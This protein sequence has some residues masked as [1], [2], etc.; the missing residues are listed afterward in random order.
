MQENVHNG[1]DRDPTCLSGTAVLAD[2]D[3]ALVREQARTM[4]HTESDATIA[5]NKDGVIIYWDRAAQAMFGYSPEEA[6]GKEFNLLVPQEYHVLNKYRIGLMLQTGEAEFKGGPVDL[7]VT[8]KDGSEI[9]S[10]FDPLMIKTQ[11]ETL[12]I[13]VA[14]DITEKE[15]AG[16]TADELNENLATLG[17]KLQLNIADIVEAA[18]TTLQGAYALYQRSEALVMLRTMSGWNLPGNVM[19]VQRQK[20]T[21]SFDILNSEKE[22]PMLYRDLEHSPF[23][24]ADPSLVKNNI[25]SCM[26]W[27]VRAGGKP[28][29][30]LSVFFNEKKDFRIIE[31]KVFEV[32]ARALEGAVE[33]LMTMDKYKLNRRKLEIANDKIKRLSRSV[34]D[35]REIEKKNL[36]MTLHDEL[37]AAVVAIFSRLSIAEEEI[38]DRDL[39]AAL[40]QLSQLKNVINSSFDGLKKIVHDLRPPEL[41]FIGLESVLKMFFSSVSAQTD[42]NIRFRCVLENAV[43]KDSITISLYRFVQECINNIIKHAEAKNAEVFLRTSGEDV[44]LDVRDDG[45]G[46]EVENVMQNSGSSKMGIWGMQMRTESLGGVFTINAGRR[47]GTQVTIRIPYKGERA[48]EH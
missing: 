16:K 2:D 18:G 19:K 15:Q 22:G 8:C 13:V 4:Y 33:H 47:W 31:L 41:D 9:F 43:L 6:L 36:A 34:M 27:P 23:A 29:G 21:V 25:R 45:R 12:F 10:E 26:G 1:P 37:G 44:C 28:V 3:I 5:I 14:R 7:S 11:N 46:F 24:E 30:V 39:D 20:G 40:A 17:Q 32:F 48:D 38:Q 42:V 35:C